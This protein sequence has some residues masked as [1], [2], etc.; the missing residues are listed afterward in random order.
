MNAIPNGFGTEHKNG[1]VLERNGSA[2]RD[3]D[4]SAIPSAAVPGL[5]FHDRRR[6]SVETP[7]PN[8]ICEAIV[9]RYE[10][11]LN[12]AEGAVLHLGAGTGELMETL[13]R[14]GFT[15]MG[16]EASPEKARQARALYGFDA[17]TF[18]HSGTEP[19]LRW[20]RRIGQTAQAV[21]YRHGWEHNLEFQALLP[22][23]AQILRPG[24]RIIAL[25]PPPPAADH[26]PHAHLSFLHEL[27]VACVLCGGGF[28][29]EG[30]DADAPEY[31]LAFTLKKI[32]PWHE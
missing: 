28:E 8:D 17:R 30:I 16:C 22:M 15:V 11:R 31:F 32:S 13:R 21:F 18:H 9:H 3:F 4:P 19:F 6:P 12:A 20:L 2:R 7:N 25:L 10:S 1:A 27:A 29:M 5:F 23:L 14:H 26:P 24:G